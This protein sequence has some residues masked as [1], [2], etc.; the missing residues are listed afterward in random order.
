MLPHTHSITPDPV[1]MDPWIAFG[2]NCF[3]LLSGTTG[4]AP[5]SGRGYRASFLLPPCLQGWEPIPHS[6]SAQ[7]YV[8]VLGYRSSFGPHPTWCRKLFHPLSLMYPPT[9]PSDSMSH[10]F[11][12][13]PCSLVSQRISPDLRFFERYPLAPSVEQH[14]LLLGLLLAGNPGFSWEPA[15]PRMKAKDLTDAYR[16]L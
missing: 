5:P 10:G 1:Y 15:C 3:V 6:W 2:N 12:G 4:W 9:T 11:Q 16:C 8:Q 7:P 14:G 13:T